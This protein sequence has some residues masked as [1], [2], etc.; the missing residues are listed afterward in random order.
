MRIPPLQ[1]QHLQLRN[2]GKLRKAAYTSRK[3]P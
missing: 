3:N 2:K 1:I